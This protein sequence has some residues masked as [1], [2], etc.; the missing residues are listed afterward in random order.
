MMKNY[1]VKQSGEL[2]WVKLDLMK[3]WLKLRLKR[4]TINHHHQQGQN[5][6][7]LNKPK[8]KSTLMVMTKINREIKVENLKA[9]D[10]KMKM[11]MDQVNLNHK[12]IQK[13]IKT[14]NR[15]IKLTTSLK[16][17]LLFGT[18]RWMKHL[19]I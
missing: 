16:V 10:L 14:Y 6:R 9:L 2:A 4:T 5:H 1:H 3:L 13:S 7:S 17:C 12:C 18:S 8:I 19:K 15:S 11:M